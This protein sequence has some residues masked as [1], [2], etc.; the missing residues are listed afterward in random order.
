M[1]A[2]AVSSQ[3]EKAAIQALSRRLLKREALIYCPRCGEGDRTAPGGVREQEARTAEKPGESA[4]GSRRGSAGGTGRGGRPRVP[5]HPAC[6]SGS[7]E[8]GGDAAPSAVLGT[9]EVFWQWGQGARNW[10]DESSRP[11]PDLEAPR[12]CAAPSARFRRERGLD[13]P[14]SSSACGVHSGR[15]LPA[16]NP[17]AAPCPVRRMGSARLFLCV[18]GTHDVPATLQGQALCEGRPFSNPR[19]PRSPETVGKGSERAPI[20]IGE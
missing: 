6:D 15:A 19:A 7:S 9:T 8:G 14:A 20:E 2:V 3:G 10:R 18:L 12:R 17:P 11:S 1:S 13:A 5:A 4:P 16:P